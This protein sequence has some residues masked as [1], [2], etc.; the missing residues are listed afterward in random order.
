[1]K[2][3]RSVVQPAGQVQ[4]RVETGAGVPG[5]RIRAADIVEYAMKVRS[6]TEG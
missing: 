2:A 5:L 4:E 6:R 1:M 3:C